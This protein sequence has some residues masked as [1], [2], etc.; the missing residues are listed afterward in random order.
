M[1]T[2]VSQKISTLFWNPG[3]FIIINN[4]F[5][6]LAPIDNLEYNNR[7]FRVYQK[8]ISWQKNILE[9][10]KSAPK[11]DFCCLL[12]YFSTQK[13]RDHDMSL[14]LL[15]GNSFSKT[16]GEEKFNK[17]SKTFLIVRVE[18]QYCWFV[19]FRGFWALRVESDPLYDQ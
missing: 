3:H 12:I 4:I 10:V 14:P 13:R 9:H 18:G 16:L 11:L 15:P 7:N 1:L 2:A 5:K 19:G 8:L 6:L 17:V